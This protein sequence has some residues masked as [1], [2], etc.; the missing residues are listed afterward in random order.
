MPTN[1]DKQGDPSLAFPRRKRRK[2]PPHTASSLFFLLPSLSREFPSTPGSSR[3]GSVFSA[4]LFFCCVSF[5]GSE[6]KVPSFPSQSFRQSV[7]GAVGGK[8]IRLIFPGFTRRHRRRRLF[9]LIRPSSDSFC[10]VGF[11]L[12][13]MEGVHGDLQGP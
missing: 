8:K 5:C 1:L 11:F 6:S 7:L 10:S 9:L 2:K 4:C 12:K 3:L 13:R